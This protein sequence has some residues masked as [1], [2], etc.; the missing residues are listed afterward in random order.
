V[1]LPE[2]VAVYLVYRTPWV[3]QGGEIDFRHDFYGRDKR[4]NSLF[5]KYN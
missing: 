1:N 4:L 2:A 5:E 3:G